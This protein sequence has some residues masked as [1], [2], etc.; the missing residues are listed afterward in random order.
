MSNV[1]TVKGA[2]ENGA[3]TVDQVKSRTELNWI[4]ARDILLHLRDVGEAE[5]QNDMFHLVE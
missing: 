2:L 1:L 3:K 4:E 5:Q